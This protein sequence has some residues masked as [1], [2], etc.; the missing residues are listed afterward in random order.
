M[1]V[2][3]YRILAKQPTC[4]DH[5]AW[6][7][8]LESCVME[9]AGSQN[10]PVLTLSIPVLEQIPLPLVL[11]FL[12][13]TE[14][15]P[16]NKLRA[17]LS[18]EDIDVRCC[19]IGT[20]SRIMLE[21]AASITNG[22]LMVFPFES[23]EARIC[24]Q[25]DVWTMVVD[26][27]KI[28]FQTLL[29][30]DVHLQ[31]AVG[32]AFAAMRMLFAR[33][34]AMAPFFSLTKTH[35]RNQAAMN[36]IAS[37]LYRDAYPLARTLIDAVRKLPMKYQATGAVW[38]A[39]LLYMMMERTGA[40]CPSVSVPYL[41]LDVV[42]AGSDNL[43]QDESDTSSTERVRID[44]LVAEQLESWMIP[45]LSSKTSLSQS[46][47]ICRAIFILLSHPMQ[48][49]SRLTHSATLVNHMTAQCAFNKN[50]ATK[51]EFAQMLVRAFSW[52]SSAGWLIW[53]TRTVDAVFLV[54][55][56]AYVNVH[57]L[58]LFHISSLCN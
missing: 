39:T 40:R 49:F 25:Q 33:T 43:D 19:A 7:F 8:V 24:C 15:E 27:W 17:I 36:D 11:G 55:R 2:I 28:I 12:V 13:S 14:K 38:I 26:V 6:N 44:Q 53:F 45:L 4:L 57:I 1:K 16:M 10:A 56:E 58:L 50:S 31:D 51:L 18:H 54:D 5:D 41:S 22:G 29:L 48:E 21:I 52:L 46:S 20:L 30:P 34:S 47:S 3:G 23:H 35:S 42:N 37:A 32:A 9:L